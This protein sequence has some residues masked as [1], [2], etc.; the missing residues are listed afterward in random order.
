[1]MMVKMEAEPRAVRKLVVRMELAARAEVARALV[2]RATVAR[3]VVV[4]AAVEMMARAATV[5]AG[6]ELAAMG[7]G[8]DEGYWAKVAARAVEAVVVRVALA[9]VE[10]VG[11]AVVTGG[12]SRRGSSLARQRGR[13][14]STR[15]QKC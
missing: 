9:A 14:K 10:V 13:R 6:A 2:G 4:R 11:A 1:M 12:R 5:R 8:A 7:F 15:P 3:V